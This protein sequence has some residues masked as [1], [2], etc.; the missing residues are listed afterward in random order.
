MDVLTFQR[1]WI[2]ASRQKERSVDS[3]REPDHL[4]E[5]WLN[6]EGHPPPS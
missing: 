3:A 5:N 4:R 2:D 1:K 6:P